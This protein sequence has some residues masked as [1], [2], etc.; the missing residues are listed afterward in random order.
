VAARHLCLG[1]LFTVVAHSV[2]DAIPLSTTAGAA[3]GAVALADETAAGAKYWR[4]RSLLKVPLEGWVLSKLAFFESP[5]GSGEEAKGEPLF[6]TY[7]KSEEVPPNNE[8]IAAH[9]FDGKQDTVW[10]SL[11][12]E[13]GQFIGVEFKENKDI[14]SCVMRTPDMVKGPG[15]VM[16]EK[17]DDG[18]TFA[19]VAEI[20]DMKEWGTKD[21]LY[22]FVPMDILP[23]SVFSI[24]SQKDPAYC[25]GVRTRKE[26][27]EDEDSAI[28]HI[29]EGAQLELQ[30][31]LDDTVTQWWSFDV[32]RGLLHSAA[33]SIYI[34]HVQG[35]LAASYFEIKKCIEGCPDATKDEFMYS[36]SVRGGFLRQRTGRQNIV[37]SVKDGEIKQGNVVNLGECGS[38]PEAAA[39]L[40]ACPENQES[41]WE[42]VPMFA[43]EEHTQAIKCSPYSHN[44]DDPDPAATRQEAQRLCAADNECSA[45]NWADN[46]VEDYP[47]RVYLCHK[48]H[49]VHP[50][51][52]GWELG[53]RAGRAYDSPYEKRAALLDTAASL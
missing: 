48:L 42:L 38:D 53:V 37:I 14:K 28:I 39:E 47:N 16:V 31:C 46:S 44:L 29:E 49:D 41:Q 12:G 34:A 9:A 43:L 33:D 15:A 19:R 8:F 5:D 50:N 35:D 32:A 40:N 45:Y 2:E 3:Q 36:D 6:S 21:Q 11:D 25:I 10:E 23:S 30:K 13:P 52:D 4:V 7:F 17:S 18:V 20:S 26:F 1:I 24:R 22:K 27:P 51:A